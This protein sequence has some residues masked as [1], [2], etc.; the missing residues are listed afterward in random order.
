MPTMGEARRSSTTSEVA[1]LGSFAVADG[2]ASDVLSFPLSSAGV[3]AFNAARGGFFSIGGRA[4][5]EENPGDNFVYGFS[6]GTPGSTQ[7]LVVT[8]LLPQTKAEC[9]NNGWRGA[10]VFKNEGD[11]V[12]F[13]ATR[14]KNPP[15]G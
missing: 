1:T 10:G 14:G 9:K 4:S 8:C 2:P 12:S 5:V 13:V 7:Q 3:S 11:C 15:A 6:S